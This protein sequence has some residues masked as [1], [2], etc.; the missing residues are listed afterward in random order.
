MAHVHLLCIAS[1]HIYTEVIFAFRRYFEE[2]GHLFTYE[3]A[4]KVEPKVQF[5]DDVNIVIKAQ[6]KFSPDKLPKKSLKILFQS[7]QYSK[8]RAFDSM[9]F[10]ENW[11][12]ILDVFQDNVERAQFASPATVRFFPIGYHRAYRRHPYSI[13]VTEDQLGMDCYF[14]GARTNYRTTF[15]NKHV[16]PYVDN[17][18]LANQ[19]F[20]EEKYKY[21]VHSRINLFIPATE[22]YYLPTMHI[23]QIIANKKFLIVVSDTPQDFAPYQPGLHFA[24]TT[25]KEA[26]HLIKAFLDYPE[27]R[28]RF[29][30]QC[31]QSLTEVHSFDNYLDQG[32]NGFL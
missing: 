27:D 5:S 29:Q 23:M 7:E 20:G 26:R 32:L 28:K 14:F 15:W 6:R 12:L 31:F 25:T 8:L 1:E 9:A 24:L 13:W 18:R 4:F 22:P 17:C 30:E 16:K 3:F 10:S 11:D 19:D 21:I 2:K